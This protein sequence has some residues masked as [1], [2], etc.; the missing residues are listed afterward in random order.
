[1]IHEKLSDCPH[2]KEPLTRW[3]N[4]Q[5]S[6]W[7]GAFQFVC[8]ND[9]CP[10]FVRGWEWMMSRYNVAASYRFRFD[11]QSGDTGPLPVWSREAL[12]DGIVKESGVL[13]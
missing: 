10:Y 13:P 4:P 2:C 5:Q 3:T 12:K 1:M 7:G 6:T 11:P 9:A 8:F